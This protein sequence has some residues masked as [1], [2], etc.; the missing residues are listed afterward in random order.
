MYGTQQH[1]A[2]PTVPVFDSMGGEVPAQAKA[3]S[4]PRRGGSWS[5]VG[6]DKDYLIKKQLDELDRQQS[7]LRYCEKG[8]MSRLHADAM[9]KNGFAKIAVFVP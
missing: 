5:D 1:L 3:G 2:T 9:Q 8:I 4:S 7:Y 6:A